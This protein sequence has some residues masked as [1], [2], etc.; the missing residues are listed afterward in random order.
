[1]EDH[2]QETQ[3]RAY[4][5]R[6]VRVPLDPVTR[7]KMRHNGTLPDDYLARA[8]EAHDFIEVMAATDGEARLKAFAATRLVAKGEKL[9][10][11]EQD[12]A[13]LTGWREL[14]A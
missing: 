6:V 14:A 3:E 4:T 10:V 2:M 13:A 1:M 5:L 8:L 11:E 12:D 7:E 9:V